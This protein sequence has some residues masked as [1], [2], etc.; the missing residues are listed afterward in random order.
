MH[1]YCVFFNFQEAK[2]AIEARKAYQE[3]MSGL[4]GSIEM[5]T[6][7]KEVA[8]ERAEMLQSEVETLKE[9]VQELEIELELLHNEMTEK[10]DQ[11]FVI[12]IYFI[13]RENCDLNFPKFSGGE[14]GSVNSVQM[15]QLEQQNER[16]KEAVV[17]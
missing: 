14:S 9:K 6:L 17:K 3:E 2:E 10:G 7:D 16:L 5:A 15:K 12:T 1:F 4:A 11:F 8:E 13:K